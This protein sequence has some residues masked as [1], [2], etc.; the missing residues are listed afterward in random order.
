MIWK[1]CVRLPEGDGLP[2]ID[3]KWVCGWTLVRGA[4]FSCVCA[5]RTVWTWF[6]IGGY[7]Q[8]GHHVGDWAMVLALEVVE[9]VVVGLLQVA[10]VL[11]LEVVEVPVWVEAV[12][13][14]C[15]SWMPQWIQS[16]VGVQE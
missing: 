14:L 15:E 8:N 7:V 3:E 16:C 2:W 5:V 12:G 1:S 11:Q 6:E 10:V 9:V 4:K 13:W